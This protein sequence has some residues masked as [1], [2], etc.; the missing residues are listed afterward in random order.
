MKHPGWIKSRV[1][2]IAIPTLQISTSGT[3]QEHKG[4]PSAT[5]LLQ[6][7]HTKQR[8][9]KDFSQHLSSLKKMESLSLFL[10]G[11]SLFSSTRIY[12]LEIIIIFS[13]H[14]SIRK[15]MISHHPQFPLYVKHA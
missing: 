5:S 10:L 8:L 6:N 1:H 12:L 14:E 13:H 4:A 9:Q 11:R 3:L 7:L 15:I 2:G